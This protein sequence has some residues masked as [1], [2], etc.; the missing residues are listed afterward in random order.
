[1]HAASVGESLS[2]LALL[3]E[4]R[5]RHPNISIVLTSG[6]LTSAAALAGRLPAGVVHQFAPVDLPGAVST[7]LG[8]WR[9]ALAL[10]VE[11]ELWPNTLAALRRNSI[12]L[13]LLNARMSERSFRRWRRVPSA[14]A[15]VLRPF[16]VVLAQSAA[17][18][19]R[20]TA[21]GATNVSVV[22][23]LK[24]GADELSADQDKLAEA[25][26]LLGSRPRWLAASTHP[27]EE[28][29]VAEAHLSMSARHP[30]LA[31]VIVPRHPGRG[32]EVAALL[33]KRGLKVALRSR[34]DSL[35]S[36]AAIYVADTL[37]EL[38]LWYRLC[39]ISF[40]GGSLVPHG[41]H[42]LIE[43]AQLGSAVIVG[44]YVHNFRDLAD[45]MAASAALT[46]VE[47]GKRLAESVLA[48]LE[49]PAIARRAAAAGRRFAREQGGATEQVM[50]RL[51]PWFSQLSTERGAAGTR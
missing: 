36:E 21:L 27:G 29:V 51:G 15:E 6:T 38:G 4:L 28:E 9:P 2:V 45:A 11:S 7:F 16:S 37:G 17:D 42:N 3:A 25:G 43:P 34:Q 19:A 39:P 20:F 46:T 48:M 26:A 13:G 30:R 41:G 18:A 49:D 24:L 5:R 8:H 47:N 35:S 32:A 22:S 50:E 40:V 33:A 14:A 12:P 23:N 10:W 1:M 31:T 44:P